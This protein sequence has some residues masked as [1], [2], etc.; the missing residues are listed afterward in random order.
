MIGVWM[1]RDMLLPHLF[2]TDYQ[3][4]ARKADE[5][6]NGRP[7]MA[8]R[9]TT[10]AAGQAE[11]QPRLWLAAENGVRLASPQHEPVAPID[12]PET[13]MDVEF[14]GI[15]PEAQRAAVAGFPGGSRFRLKS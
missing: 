10:T 8:Q 14:V 1:Q 15:S 11:Q 6:F 2:V 7:E 9:L 5:R 3:T 12:E 13:P 4:A